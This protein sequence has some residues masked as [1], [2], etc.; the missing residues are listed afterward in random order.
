MKGFVM[1]P[2]D[3]SSNEFLATD[4]P[5]DRTHAFLDLVIH[6]THKERTLLIRNAGV[7]LLPG[8]MAS[9]LRSLSK[10]WNRS[11][12]YVI[13]T[14]NCLSRQGLVELKPQ[15]NITIVRI[16]DWHRYQGN[17]YPKTRDTENYPSCSTDG[18]RMRDTDKSFQ[19]EPETQ[20]TL[21][22]QNYFKTADHTAPETL[23]C[24]K[25]GNIQECLNNNNKYASDEA[26]SLAAFFLSE[27]RKNN[28][29]LKPRDGAM[30]D[31]TFGRM[32]VDDM[33][34]PG[35]LRQLINFSQKNPF[36]MKQITSPYKIKVHFH[37][38]LLDMQQEE[39]KNK[40]LVPSS[41]R[42]C[43]EK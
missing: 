17:S 25:R 13:K 26:S 10:R 31:V 27:I 28:P 2:R 40:K 22:L 5:F 16:I 1:I 23:N 34:P 29:F 4:E 7:H 42:L 35:V 37:K 41:M 39:K 8:E 9:S 12:G 19:N 38:L 11:I 36:W 21:P 30:W 20:E 15:R 43:Y 6:A 33:V 18:V 14:L 3:I 32:I 24:P